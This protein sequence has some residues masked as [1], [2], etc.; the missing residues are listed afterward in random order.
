MQYNRC[1][2]TAVIAAM[3]AHEYRFEVKQEEKFGSF[4]AS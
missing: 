2:V 1:F 3:S 4:G